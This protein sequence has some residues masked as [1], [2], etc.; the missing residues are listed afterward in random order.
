[1]KLSRNWGSSFIVN[2]AF[3]AISH[4]LLQTTYIRSL[5]VKQ[6]G[7]NECGGSNL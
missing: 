3:F 7:F 1:M 2:T 5:Y 4:L 6:S